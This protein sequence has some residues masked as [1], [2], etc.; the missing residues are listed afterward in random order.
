LP[1]AW[2]ERIGEVECPQCD[3]EERRKGGEDLENEST[4][5]FHP[6]DREGGNATTKMAK[7]REGIFNTI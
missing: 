7:L 1:S 5:Q 6:A 3:R 4:S 2:D